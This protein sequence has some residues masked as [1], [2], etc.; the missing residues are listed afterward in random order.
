MCIRD[1]PT[2]G[3]P[4]T[5]VPT[6]G[7]PT[8]GV[9]TTGVPTTGVPTTGVATTGNPTTGIPTTGNPTTAVATT[10]NPTTGVPTTGNPTTGVPTTG[11]ATTRAATTGVATTGNPTTGVPTT[12]VATTRAAT[13]GVVTTGNPTTGVATTGVVA[14]DGPRIAFRLTQ[15]QDFWMD[16]TNMA[17]MNI[18]AAKNASLT[19]GVIGGIFGGEQ[20]FVAQVR[21]ALI[22]PNWDVEV[23]ANGWKY[24]DF[25]TISHEKRVEFIGNATLRLQRIFGVSVKSFILPWGSPNADTISLLTTAGYTVVS[26]SSDTGQTLSSGQSFYRFPA[27]ATMYNPNTPTQLQTQTVIINSIQTALNNYGFAVVD[28]DPTAFD[29]TPANPSNSPN[30]TALTLMTNVLNACLTMTHNNRQV[31][32]VTLQGII[33]PKVNKQVPSYTAFGTG[34]VAWRLDDVCDE[35][36]APAQ[37]AVM[38]VFKEEN[39]PLTAGIITN[40]YGKVNTYNMTGY[41][42]QRLLT[43]PNFELACHGYLHE[44]FSLTTLAV[45]T[46][47]LKNCVDILKAKHNF[48]CEIFMPPFNALN[49]NTLTALHTNNYTMLSSEVSQDTPPYFH[50]DPLLWKFPIGA[51]TADFDS[52]GLYKITAATNTMSQIRQQLLAYGYS[53]VMLHPQEYTRY[54]NSTTFDPN[55]TVN[56]TA[57]DELRTLL[58][59]AKTAGF[60]NTNLGQLADY[61]WSY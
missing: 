14:N 16:N 18:F 35:Y 26:G 9:P 10:G 29:L 45:Q 58:R 19:L 24:E 47:H 34:R 44:D 1:R 57:I 56:S 40:S 21:S 50:A 5:G 59:L 37:I 48:H 23:A 4:T 30:P 51:Q 7:N 13:T 8:T 2:T 27:T 54:I 32:L 46:T 17:V 36:L 25:G 22:N 38:N 15:I 43:D 41:I 49:A 55:Q 33:N 39:I 6:T 12:G 60:T 42:S 3:N 20:P 61:E 28:I 11:V 31:S 52:N 53:A